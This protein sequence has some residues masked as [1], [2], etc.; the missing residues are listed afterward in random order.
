MTTTAAPTEE[1]GLRLRVLLSGLSFFAAALALAWG[2]LVAHAHPLNPS[3]PCTQ[4]GT[5]GAD[6]LLGTPGSDVLCGLGGPDTIAGLGGDDIL[7]GGNGA[8]RIQGDGGRDGLYGGPG[9]DVL[10]AY[11]GTHDHLHGGPGSDR[12][13]RDRLVDVARGIESF[14][15][16]RRRVSPARACT[17]AAPGRSPGSSRRWGSRQALRA[18][19]PARRR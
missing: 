6:F 11:D 10:Y 3:R 4:T 19:R 13:R 15:P 12:A 17:R 8:D 18:P 1:I 7:R 14:T 16:R 2:P 9:A 5:P